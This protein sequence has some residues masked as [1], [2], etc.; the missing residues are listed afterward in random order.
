MSVHDSLPRLKIA[1]VHDWLTGMRGGEK[2]LEV[3]C[4]LFPHA[5]LYTLVHIP[6]SVSSL[7]EDRPI[8]TSFIQ[9]LPG[10]A[11]QYRKYLPLFPKAIEGLDLTGYDLVISIS[12]CAAKGVSARPGGLHICYCNTPM[13]Y[14][15]DQYEEY[16]GKGRAGL[17]TRLAMS[18]AAPYLRAWDVRTAD[19]V[20]HYIANSRNVQERISRIYHRESEVIY[21]PVDVDRYTV[22]DRPRE[23]ALVVSALVPYKRVDLAVESFNRSGK[24]LVIVGKGPDLDRL[25]AVARPNVEFLGWRSDEDLATLY[26]QASALIFPGE[27]DFGIVPLEA[28]ASGTPVVAYGKGGALETVIDGVTGVFFK[29]QTMDSLDDAIS[30]AGSIAWNAGRM[31]EQ[32]LGFSRAVYRRRM[33][34]SL[35]THVTAGF[36]PHANFLP[37]E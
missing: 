18:V 35:R 28:T 11:S 25:R 19:R 31:R 27:E 34:E 1:L 5:P 7:I 3:L 21:P 16:F 2:C 32:A 9:Q 8:Y 22:L 12:V 20:H 13:R 17:S 36:G 37:T 29:D 23:F 33:I 6:G 15:W 4:E 14:V 24:R 10:A 26:Q 30:R